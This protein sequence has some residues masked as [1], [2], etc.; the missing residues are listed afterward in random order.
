MDEEKNNEAVD[1]NVEM[2]ETVTVYHDCPRCEGSGSYREP[3][4]EGEQTEAQGEKDETCPACKGEGML[5]GGYILLEDIPIP[6]VGVDAIVQQVMDKLP[7]FATTGF[8]IP[9]FDEI[10]AME[11][12]ELRPLAKELHVE[13]WWNMKKE[14]LIKSIKAKLSD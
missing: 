11:I 1:S 8:S 13:Q 6:E 14:D 10:D 5:P 3:I 7:E 12:K 9:E 2:Q 4:D